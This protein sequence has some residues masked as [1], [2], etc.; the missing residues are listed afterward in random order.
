MDRPSA[1]VSAS[2]ACSRSGPR[3]ARP[4]CLN[5]SDGACSPLVAA[6]EVESHAKGGEYAPN[7]GPGMSA[8]RSTSLVLAER[9]MAVEPYTCTA[10][11]GQSDVRT[12][13]T[14]VRA[15]SAFVA[16]SGAVE[17]SA[18]ASAPS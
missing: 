9:P 14:R 8:H 1:R 7:D 4:A 11:P 18:H 13:A 16:A 12:S 2:A 6:C 15:L 3:A 5:G 10:D 17:S